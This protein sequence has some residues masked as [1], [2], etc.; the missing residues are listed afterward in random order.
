[1]SRAA[2]DH[3]FVKAFPD[4]LD[5]GILYVSVEFSTAAHRCFCGCGSEVYTR[6]SPR[7]WSM[8]FNGEVVSIN[9]SIGNWS[10]PCQSH[11][12]LDGGRVHWADKWSRER[13]ELGRLLDRDRKERHYKGELQASPPPRPIEPAS[14][15]GILARFTRWLTAR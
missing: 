14:R 6:F 8:K 3:K 1:M 11:Y 15:P 12:I 2:Y 9:P 7:D 5:E 13:I 4:K 10:F